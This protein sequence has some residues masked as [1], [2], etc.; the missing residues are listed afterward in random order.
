V[1]EALGSAAGDRGLQWQEAAIAAIVPRTPRVKSFF[2]DLP[3]PFSFRPGQHVDVRLTAADGYRAERSYS[4]AS[5]P[6]PGSVIELAVERLDDGEVS[7]FFHDVATV[8]DTIELRGPIGGYFV[9]EVGDG[10]PLLLF[11]GGSGVVPFMS[12]IRQRSIC[13][14]DVPVLLLFSSRTFEEVLFREELLH[15]DARNDGFTLALAL[16]REPPRRA[17]D[18]GR[19]VDQDMVTELLGRL[20]APPK[21][22]FICGSNPFVGAAADAAISAG[23]P[24]SLIRTERYGG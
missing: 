10:G 19:R 11:A 8:G 12:M 7:T 16:T 13:R 1:T 5:A 22:I 6:G 18:Y 23:I 14:S 15:L 24:A 2:F 3:R 4:I 17:H 21:Q 9:W 20:P